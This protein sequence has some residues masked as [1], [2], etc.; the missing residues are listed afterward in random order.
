MKTALSWIAIVKVMVL[1]FV[2]IGLAPLDASGQERKIATRLPEYILEEVVLHEGGTYR[3]TIAESVPDE[4][5]VFVTVSGKTLRF[6]M[7]EIEYSGPVR[8]A[9]VTNEMIYERPERLMEAPVTNRQSPERPQRLVST[10]GK[11]NLL[12]LES[13]DPDVDFHMLS[14]TAEGSFSSTY[15]Y[16]TASMRSYKHICSAPCEISLPAGKYKLALSKS[17]NLPIETDEAVEVTQPSVLVGKVE[18]KK[19]IRTAGWIILGA[20]NALGLGLMGAAADDLDEGLLLAGT[21]IALSST[22]LALILILV[23][24][25]ATIDVNPMSF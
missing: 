25:D 4:Y 9:A 20:G 13:P 21:T 23:K 1:Q 19:H 15:S 7:N 18:S 3:G 11:E 14:S 2:A 10:L 17:G 16:G 5:L 8:H 6:P 24:D 22:V 12:R